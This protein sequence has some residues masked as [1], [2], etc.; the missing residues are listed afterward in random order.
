MPI[1]GRWA[2]TFAPY[3]AVSSAA[4]GERRRDQSALAWPRRVEPLNIDAE[5]C[6]QSCNLVDVSRAENTHTIADKHKDGERE[7]EAF[8]VA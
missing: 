8:I 2:A 7:R 4:L 1:N 5:R 6:R 3:R